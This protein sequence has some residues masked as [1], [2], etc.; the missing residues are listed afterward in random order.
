MIKLWKFWQPWKVFSFSSVPLS[1]ST[2]WK[3]PGRLREGERGLSAKMGTRLRDINA[4][5]SLHCTAVCSTFSLN[6]AFK[7]TSEARIGD[8]NIDR[9]KGEEGMFSWIS[10]SVESEWT[11][12][13]AGGRTHVI[14]C[15]SNSFSG[16]SSNYISFLPPPFHFHLSGS[17]HV[18]GLSTDPEIQQNIPTSVPYI[19][20]TCLLSDPTPPVIN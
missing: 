4:L 13:W 15:G 5:Y 18:H 7:N 19:S 16:S 14:K 1:A 2:S 10:G 11:W 6:F 12:A 9:L 20:G 3:L 8:I 17:A